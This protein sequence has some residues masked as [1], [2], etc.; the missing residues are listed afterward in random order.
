MTKLWT[1]H[2]IYPVK[3]YFNLQPSSVALTLEVGDR[4]FAH[5]TYSDYFEQLWQLFT[6]SLQT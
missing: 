1:G 3:D 4:F 2:A 6:K 5:D